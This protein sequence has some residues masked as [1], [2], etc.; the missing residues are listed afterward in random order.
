MR[1][2]ILPCSRLLRSGYGS[3]LE[4]DLLADQISVKATRSAVLCPETARC[5][6]E[7]TFQR[8]RDFLLSRTSPALNRISHII[9]NQLH[10]G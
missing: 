3:D 2:S 5:L 4:I 9:R 1:D 8:L 6:L 7:F 10:P